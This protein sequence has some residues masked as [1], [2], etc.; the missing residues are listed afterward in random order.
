MGKKL[1][2][3]ESEINTIR[4]MYGLIME[5]VSE[6][7]VCTESGCSGKYTGPEFSKDCSDIAHQYSNVITKAV[8]TKLKELYKSGNYVKVDLD[9]IKLSATSVNNVCNQNQTTYS[10]TIPFIK[11]S[12]KCDAMTGFAHV[13]GWGHKPELTARKGEIWGYIPPGKSRNTVVD[14]LLDVSQLTKTPTG[15]EEY[16]IQWKHWDYQSDCEKSNSDSQMSLEK[17]HTVGDPNYKPISNSEADAIRKKIG[18][19]NSTKELESTP[20]TIIEPKSDPLVKPEVKVTDKPEIKSV[21]KKAKRPA[22]SPDEEL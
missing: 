22:L 2:I 6:T 3:S 19:L 14:N 18:S 16:W 8:A 20:K 4:G 1:I 9:N 13:G 10:I 11:V 5:Q 17:I 12:N 7:P 21:I 15:L